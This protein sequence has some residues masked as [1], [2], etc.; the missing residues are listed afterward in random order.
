MNNCWWVVKLS[1]ECGCVFFFRDLKMFFVTM[2]CLLEYEGFYYIYLCG[3]IS[4]L[5]L[6]LNAFFFSSFYFVWV[7]FVAFF[8]TALANSNRH[9]LIAFFWIAIFYVF[10]YVLLDIFCN[11]SCHVTLRH[12]SS[13]DFATGCALRC[14]LE[15]IHRMIVD[16]LIT[17]FISNGWAL[18]DLYSNSG[19]WTC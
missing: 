18:C 8:F 14:F 12:F 13:R 2:Q 16:K 10:V 4:Y 6:I 19:T 17:Y 5:Q 7:G 15:V 1:F 9:K 11:T 3:T